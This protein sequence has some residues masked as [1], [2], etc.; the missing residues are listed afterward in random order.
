MLDGTRY[1]DQGHVITS[2]GISAGI[3]MSLH[4]VERLH[5]SDAATYTARRMEYEWTRPTT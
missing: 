4:V 1:V 3:D 5:G 2:A